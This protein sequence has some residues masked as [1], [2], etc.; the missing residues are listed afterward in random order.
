M[1]TTESGER[2][3]LTGQV[4]LVTGAGRG[5]GR[6]ISQALARAGMAVAVVARSEDQLQETARLI[7][8]ADG[9]VLAVT[10][11]VTDRSSV[12]AA[13]AT[14]E[15]RLGPIDLLVNNA[16]SAS[17]VGPVAATD[18]ESWWIDVTVNLLGPMLCSHAVLPGMIERSRGR[19]I[20]VASYAGTRP[21]PNL[22]AYA[23]SKA[24]L[25]RLTDT[26]H[27]EVV[28]SGV[29]VF[30]ATPG[31]TRTAMADF[32]VHSDDAGKYFAASAPDPSQWRDPDQFG[33]LCLF[34]ASGAGDALGG[35]FVNLADDLD[36]LLRRTDEIVRDDLYALRLRK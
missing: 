13:V 16:G 29:K 2:V 8:G 5:L 7:E 1:V 36:D 24:A 35:R 22:S 9:Q 3:D 15:D 4:G 33:D 17:A 28:D 31:W 34:F 21:Y 32:L 14:I 27:A 11:D 26:M 25:L 19:V 20:N 10:V 6:S 12:D 30:A 18:P 23:C